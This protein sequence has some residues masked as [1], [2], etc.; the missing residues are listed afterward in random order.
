MLGSFVCGV[1]VLGGLVLVWLVVWGGWGLG[2]VLLGRF[3]P[4]IKEGAFHARGFAGIGAP[5]V[6]AVLL[7][8]CLP[9]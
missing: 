7:A 8:R 3:V 2:V 4:L 6:D 1:P 5:F 9:A